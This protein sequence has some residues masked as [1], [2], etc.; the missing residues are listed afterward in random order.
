MKNLVIILAAILTGAAAMADDL[1]AA[2]AVCKQ[3]DKKVHIYREWPK[4]SDGVAIGPIGLPLELWAAGWEHCAKIV[5]AK[6][7]RDADAAATDE[8]KNPDLKTTRD[9]ARKLAQ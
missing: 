9:I 6:E 3:P 5:V 4:N 1:D 7:K 2:Y 8:T